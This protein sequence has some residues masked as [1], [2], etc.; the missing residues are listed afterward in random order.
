MVTSRMTSNAS[1][2]SRNCLTLIEVMTISSQVI[3]ESLSRI[4]VVKWS[5]NF[6]FQ[7]YLLPVFAPLLPVFAPFLQFDAAYL[8]LYISAL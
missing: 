3:R 1:A 8:E 6:F 2:F 4:H 7:S 5:V